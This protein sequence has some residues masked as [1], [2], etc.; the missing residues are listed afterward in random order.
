MNKSGETAIK[1][2]EQSGL[3]DGL[4]RASYTV[5]VFLLRLAL[6]TGIQQALTVCR[7]SF[8]DITLSLDD[9]HC[10][11]CTCQRLSNLDR[12]K[13]CSDPVHKKGSYSANT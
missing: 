10:Q 12:V 13:S 11:S 7:I 3:R 5:A 4:N 9:S 1:D 2:D 6:L 8:A